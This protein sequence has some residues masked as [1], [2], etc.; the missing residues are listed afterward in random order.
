LRL[1]HFLTKFL[2][3]QNNIFGN[4]VILFTEGIKVQWGKGGN[5]VLLDDGPGGSWP[6]WNQSGC[7]A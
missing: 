7:S 2:K 5:N 1:A 6:C 4:H 3:K